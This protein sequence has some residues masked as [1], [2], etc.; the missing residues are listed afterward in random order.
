VTVDVIFVPWLWDDVN[1]AGERQ[2]FPL[3][4]AVPEVNRHTYPG[5]L[6]HFIRAQMIAQRQVAISQYVQPLVT[7]QMFAPR[8]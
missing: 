7:V 3:W 8:L 6:V 1:I 2:L 5:T 4:S